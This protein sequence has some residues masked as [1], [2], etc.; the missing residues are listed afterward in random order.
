MP[1]SCAFSA[2]SCSSSPL[3]TCLFESPLGWR[4]RSRATCRLTTFFI[5]FDRDISFMTPR[6]P[7]PR[8]TTLEQST[9]RARE[10][11]DLWGLSYPWVGIPNR[12]WSKGN[13]QNYE[14]GC[15]RRPIPSCFPS[16][17][18]RAGFAVA[19]GLR[20]A[21]CSALLLRNQPNPVGTLALPKRYLWHL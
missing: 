4:R 18:R 17:R 7:H 11:Y 2:S 12:L 14:R 19:A 6:Y 15:L 5:L 1:R 9:S 21:R 20:V 10:R 13:Y 3:E 8:L 16:C